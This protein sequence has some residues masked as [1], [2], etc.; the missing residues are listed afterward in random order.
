[1]RHLRFQLIS[2]VFVGIHSYRHPNGFQDILHRLHIIELLS[3]GALPYDP[4]HPF[5]REQTPD[6]EHDT[7]G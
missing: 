6:H 4:P 3:F 7:L 2:H 1:M 5:L